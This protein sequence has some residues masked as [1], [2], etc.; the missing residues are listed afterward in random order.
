[1]PR[2]NVQHCVIT[3]ICTAGI[4]QGVGGRHLLYAEALALSI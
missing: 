1:M 4:Q 3:F 2:S